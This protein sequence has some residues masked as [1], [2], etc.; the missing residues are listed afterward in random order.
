MVKYIDKLKKLVKGRLEVL[1]LFSWMRTTTFP[2]SYGVTL[3]DL[4]LFVRKESRQFDI[5]SRAN[6]M[7]F[8]FFLSLFPLLLVLF[9]I[10]PYLPLNDHFFETIRAAILE[11]MPG[12]TGKALY[13][14]IKD[15]TTKPQL[16]LLSVSSILVIYFASNG[17]MAMING[18][19]KSFPT[20]FE[21]WPGW[22]KRVRA[23]LLTFLLAIILLAS[24]ILIILGNVI[25]KWIYSV[26]GIVP[27]SFQSGS[28]HLL[29]W[30]VII[31]LYYTGITS[32]YRFAVSAR[33]R[34]TFFTP[35]A[36]L[37]TFLSLFTSYVFSFYIDNFSSYNK[38]Y[39]SIG[40]VI[41]M[42][43]WIQFNA[44]ILIVGFELNA[45]IAITRDMKIMEEREDIF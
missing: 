3:Y 19:E 15:L 5:S 25:L 1:G 17:V 36:T 23:I 31:A 41:A 26:T 8:N 40:T 28:Y 7:A 21:A 42:M 13:A 24:I 4:Y 44:F 30:M 27:S 37:A 2:G 18:F 10:I 38:L 6:S 43:L 12:K 35:G 20:T 16:N 11:V 33:K 9:T 32:I 29:R 34:F 45:S 39:G 14:F 22:Y